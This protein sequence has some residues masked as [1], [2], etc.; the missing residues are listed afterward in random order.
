MARGAKA[1]WM[2]S[3][4]TSTRNNVITRLE[5]KIMS[6]TSSHTILKFS[7]SEKWEQWLAV[8]HS[9]SHGAWLRFFKKHSGIPSVTY[10]AALDEA[11]CYGWIDGQLKPY[12]KNSWLRKFTPRRSNSLWSKRNRE[13]V[14]RLLEAKKIKPA[15]LKA[16]QAA[17][18]DGRWEKAYDPI[19]TIEIPAD[20]LEEVSKN[21]KAK[22][23]FESLN[24]TNTYAIAWR[25]Q[26]A[27]KSE[28]RE[29]RLKSILT[30]LDK[31]EKIHD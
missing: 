19:S 29:K 18:A 17:I 7:S 28:T 20:F 3:A 10:A 14:S 4:I 8:H 15:G 22:I 11:L 2:I 27:Q 21:E 25:L 30:M 6:T 13:H 16:I 12:D 9:I 24:K 26:T 5:Q 1:R 23:F 31:G